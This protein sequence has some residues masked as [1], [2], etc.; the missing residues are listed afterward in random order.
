MKG[1]KMASKSRDP[2]SP[3]HPGEILKTEF[4]EPHGLSANRLGLAL[5]VPANRIT[6]IIREQRGISADTALRLSKAFGTSPQLWLNL[7]TAYDLEVATQEVGADI[8]Q[9]VRTIAAE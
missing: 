4:M 7:Q 3:I 2:L 6:Q 5:G 8:E 9:S 1:R